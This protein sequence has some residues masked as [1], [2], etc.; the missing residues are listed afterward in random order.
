MCANFGRHHLMENLHNAFQSDGTTTSS[1]KRHFRILGFAISLGTALEHHARALIL[2][3]KT[4][5]FSTHPA[6]ISSQSITAAAATRKIT[7][8]TLNFSAKSGFQQPFLAHKPPS[9]SNVWSSFMN[10]R[11]KARPTCTT[12]ITR[13]S[14]DSTMPAFLTRS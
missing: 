2:G 11:Y 3:R 5:S 1:R 9:P 14:E 4:S 12:S 6:L 8:R 13:F 10:S 7:P